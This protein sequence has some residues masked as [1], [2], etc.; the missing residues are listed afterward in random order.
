MVNIIVDNSSGLLWS[1]LSV[2]INILSVGGKL[3]A[4]KIGW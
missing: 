3:M 1:S 4:D 2:G